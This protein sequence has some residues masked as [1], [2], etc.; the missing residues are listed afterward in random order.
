MQE[1]DPTPHDPEKGLS[2][3]RKL[4]NPLCVIAYHHIRQTYVVVTVFYHKMASRCTQ[5]S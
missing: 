2:W 5:K 1:K 3:E 4:M